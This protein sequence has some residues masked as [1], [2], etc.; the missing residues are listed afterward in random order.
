MTWLVSLVPLVAWQW[1]RLWHWI[2]REPKWQRVHL[3]KHVDDEPEKC[4]AGILYVIEDTGR[5]WAAAMACPCGCGQALHMNLIP[6]TKPVWNLKHES[7][8]TPTLAPSVWRQE[9]CRSHFFL[10]RGRIVWA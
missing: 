6:D 7:N 8:G 9:G 4:D 2:L 1:S 5:P 10:R 3:V